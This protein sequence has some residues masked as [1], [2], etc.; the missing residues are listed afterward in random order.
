MADEVVI[1]RDAPDGPHHEVDVNHIFFSVTDSKGIM[2]H[3]NEVFIHYAQYPEVEMIGKPHNLIRHIEMPGGAFKLMW[4]V[5]EDGHRS[6]AMSVTAQ[7]AAL[8]TTCLL[9]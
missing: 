6:Q 8:R 7:R 1:K 4:D 3:V 2:T 5:I 9:P